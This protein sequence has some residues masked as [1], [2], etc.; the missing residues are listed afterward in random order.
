MVSL[1][2]TT[3]WEQRLFKYTTEMLATPFEYGTNDCVLFASACV[4]VMTGVDL[5]R[6]Y[7]GTYSTKAGALRIIAEAGA[8]GLG[9][10]VASFLPEKEVS[11]M[12]RGDMGLFAGED[13]DFIGVCQ[14][15]ECIGPT[16][17]GLVRVKT[18]SAQRAFKV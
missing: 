9:D 1:Q 3:G 17:I 11:F 18:L 12:Q 16:R 8:G 13:G 6:N 5:A 4:E 14:G 2:R 15:K 10:F 7:R